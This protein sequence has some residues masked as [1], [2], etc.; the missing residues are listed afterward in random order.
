MA[1][2]QALACGREYETEVDVAKVDARKAFDMCSLPVYTRPR[3]SAPPGP[4]TLTSY[5]EAT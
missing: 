2:A 4:T 1:V 3:T 5:G